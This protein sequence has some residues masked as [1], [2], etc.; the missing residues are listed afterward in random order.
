MKIHLLAFASAG[1]ALG[2]S[3]MELEM[4]DGSRVSDLRDRLDRE[5]PAIAPFWPRLAVAVDGRVVS[6]EE[7]LQDGAEVA[8]LPPVSG[9]SGEPFAGLV[10][11]PLDTGQAV[12]AVS[13]P[14]RGAVVVFLGTVRDQHAGRPVDKLTYT[15]YRPMALEGLRRIVADLEAAAPGLRA[16]IV[17][18]LGEVPVGEAS[19]VIA[20]GSPH[21][22][23]AYEAS[24]TALERLKA[25]IPIWKREHYADGEEAWREEEPL[26]AV[27]T[28]GTAGTG[29]P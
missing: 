23:A 5:H 20:V 15:A 4:P 26:G 28:A 13:G 18:R 19:V 16:A 24:R 14:G 2:A 6:V 27:G 1:D 10:D 29:R 12:A 21:R 17:H 9:G 3:E 11:G 8:L 25:E 22:A 7:P